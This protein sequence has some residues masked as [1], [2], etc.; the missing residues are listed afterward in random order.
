MTRTRYAV[1]GLTM[2]IGAALMGSGLLSSLMG[3]R[4]KSAGISAG[5]MGLAMAM[6]YVGFVVGIP[7]MALVH[8]RLSRR[9]L[10]VAC[11]AVLATATAAHGVVVE[12]GA[13]LALRFVT[14]FSLAGCYLVVET[15]LNDLAENNTRGKIMGTYVA[16]AAG[17][18]ALG[19]LFLFVVDAS[20]WVPFAIAGAITCLAWLPISSVRGGAHERHKRNGS[21][22][23]IE[24]ARLVPSGV[25]GFLLVGLTQGCLLTMASVYAARAGLS[26]G[27]VAIFVG[28]ITVGAVVLQIPIGAI[29]DRGSRRGIMVAL[30]VISSVLCV[31]LL[32]TSAGSVGSYLLAFS[33][34]GFSAPL[35]AL[36]NAY[37]H[38]SLPEGQVVAASSA[39]LST[40]SIGAVFG[41]L[42]A[43]V[44][45]TAF[46]VTGFY[47]ALLVAHLSLA[48]FMGYRIAFSPERAH[49]SVAVD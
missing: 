33:L 37:T 4:S 6:Y 13:W 25:I 19:Q 29:A 36:G 16:M 43:A 39:L 24:V 7:V 46:G 23:M 12:A 5:V 38:D 17:G 31:A 47:W 9:R 44:A 28:A 34:G 15:W 32:R 42:L 41:P 8:E 14:G 11:V 49:M 22:S 3:V 10:F 21:I 1:A 2:S 45:M 26:A 20:T 48:G 30:C 27:Q 18:M 40:F 35:Y